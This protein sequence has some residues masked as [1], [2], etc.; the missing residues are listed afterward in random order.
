MYIS[1][2]SYKT[3]CILLLFISTH[4]H[5]QEISGT[6]KDGLGNPLIGA[7]VIVEG[8][9]LGAAAD[10]DGYFIIPFTPTDDFTISVSYIGFKTLKVTYSKNDP[11]THL[12]FTLIHGKL[13]GKEVTV[14]ARKREETIKEVPI[15]MVSIRQETIEDM[16]ATSIEDLTAAVPNVFAYDTQL[17]TGFNIRGITGGAR[18]PG[19]ATAEGVYLDGVIM[20][21]PNFISSDIVD[22]QSV[23]FL[24]GPQG[25]LFG[26]NT[27]SGAINMITV[28]PSPV[29]S[30]SFLIEKGDLGYLKMKGSVNYR[31]A[32]KIYGRFSGYSFDHDGYLTNT[33]DKSREKYKN[34]LG[35]R[36]AIRT[37]PTPK[38]TLD[39]SFDYLHEDLK[40]IG[41]HVSDWRISS[42]YGVYD[43]KSLDSIMFAIDSSIIN[44]DGIYS[45]NHDTTGYTKRDL[46]GVTLNANYQI[47]DYMS[48]ISVFS[49]RSS[50]VTWFN[51]ED[52]IALDIMTGDW[53]NFGEQSTFELRLVS[54]TDSR[55]SWLSGIFY[56]NIYERLLAPVFP[57]P[58]FFHI[59][60]GIPMFL[61]ESQFTGATVKP[62][63]KGNTVSVGTYASVDFEV[64]DKLVITTG[65]RYSLDSKHF[66][67][68]QEGI[69][70]FG[71]I[72]VPADSNGNLIDGYFDSTKTWSAITPSFNV[73]YSVNPLVNVFGTI[74]KGYKSGGFNTDYV[75]SYE[76]IATPFKPEYITNYELGI[77]G[78]NQSN[79]L[80]INGALFR[81]E[82][83][84]MQVSQ[85]QDL[86]EG[87]SIS[88]AGKATITGLELDFS[89]RLF[90]NSLTLVGGYGRNEA[91]FNE[92]H[93][94]YFNGY[95]D[96]GETFTDENGNGV[97]DDGEPLDDLDNDYSGNHISTFPKQ[98]WSLMADFRMPINSKIMFVTQLR[99]DYIDEKLSQ[100]STDKDA[101]LLRD[102]ARTLVNGHLGVESESWGVYMWGENLMDTEYIV[103]QGV[104]GYL[105][106][107]E[108]LWGQPRLLGIRTTFKF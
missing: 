99:S 88:N 7:N 103:Q 32:D 45:Y 76:S 25:T 108:Q 70:S 91:V 48:M 46:K 105:G 31:I 18:N 33:F 38:L 3:V 98:S 58:L 78:G 49:Y 10:I 43:G 100:L 54:N 69:T 79:T 86:F 29:N 28:K 68:R 85:F 63:G 22:L 57:K 24:R 47:N 13:F 14:L 8:T 56:Y 55:L 36:F 72:H 89:V 39:I 65:A 52:H 35:G 81:M 80:F 97:W 5:G 66:K 27:V 94:G 2:K 1:Q 106:F 93:D 9:N 20:G 42:N 83:T 19:M 96:E 26:R 101:N 67:Y 62:E 53:N 15:S 102:D 12:K 51:D 34:N 73:K 71:Y 84:D 60:A 107:I 6:V 75:S 23:E 44:D 16:G 4:I 37:V 30:S 95:W 40:D 87:Y 77:K 11:M 59:A 21:R 61:A 74:S 50:L 104:N 17:E 92:F 41:G 90:N 64:S 82:Y